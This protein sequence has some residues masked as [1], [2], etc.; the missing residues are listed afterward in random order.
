MPMPCS[1]CSRARPA[2]RRRGIERMLQN[3]AR[4]ADAARRGKPARIVVKVNGLTDR[5]LIAALVDAARAG[6]SIDLIV[7]GVC[8]LRPGVPGLTE[9]IRV[10]SLIGR[11]LEH[12]RVVYFRW[13]QGADD[14]VL[15]LT[16]ADWMTRNMRRR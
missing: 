11:F 3:I 2:S 8:S 6:A 16:S 10:R 12:S 1:G 15:Y 4:V 7:R 5:E 13:G 9:S 14:E